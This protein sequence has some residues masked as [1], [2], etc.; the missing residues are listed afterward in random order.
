MGAIGDADIAAVNAG[1][2]DTSQKIAARARQAS[3]ANRIMGMGSQEKQNGSAEVSGHPSLK[4]PINRV[5]K[6]ETRRAIGS[7]TVVACE[8]C[9]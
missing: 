4:I 1:S 8:N 7:K 5:R 6:P 2:L 3:T 9:R